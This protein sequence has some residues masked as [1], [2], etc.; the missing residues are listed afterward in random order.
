MSKDKLDILFVN[1]FY[2]EVE[3]FSIGVLS[4]VTILEN[5][6]IS[7]RIVDLNDD[8]H[9]GIVQVGVG[10]C[11]D[12]LL[13]YK[14]PIIG[15]SCM[16]N[17]Y[18][19]YLK[20]AEQIKKVNSDTIILFGGPQ[21]SMTAE[22]T[23]EMFQ[24]IDGVF[25]GE[26]EEVIVDNIRYFLGCGDEKNLKNILDRKNGCVI[27]AKDSP[28]IADLDTLP[29]LNYDLLPNFNR[30][31]TILIESGRGC[32]F[33]CVF[34]STKTFWKRKPRLKSVGRLIREIEEIVQKYDVHRFTM[35]HDLFT[36]NRAY[37]V[38]FCNQIINSSIDIKWSCSARVDTVDA[39]LIK[40]MYDAGC[41]SIF[42]GV[43]VGSE[44]MQRIIHKGLKLNTIEK[45]L[46]ELSKYN[47]D[48]LAFSFM[49]NFPDE[50]EESIHST[51]QLL[52]H[53]LHD[54]EFDVQLGQCCLLPGT[55][56]YEKYCDCLT[57]ESIENSMTLSLPIDMEDSI[58]ADAPDIFTQYYVV[59]SPVF[60]KYL[61]LEP[62]M[63]LYI[64]LFRTF[65]G[66]LEVINHYYKSDFF[67]FYEE[68]TNENRQWLLDVLGSINFVASYYKEGN[69]SQLEAGFI[70]LEHLRAWFNGRFSSEE[71]AAMEELICYLKLL[72]KCN[73]GELSNSVMYKFK[74]DVVGL[75][76]GHT[77]DNCIGR[78]VIVKL[79]RQNDGSVSVLRKFADS[80]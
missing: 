23:M 20:I 1:P 13:S 64:C 44:K 69:Y 5:N 61:L 78:G 53:I 70:M 33:S 66:V 67:K 8:F 6:S 55:E 16:S 39:E 2:Y 37:V 10:Q 22:R 43:E 49:Y 12:Y 71:I 75:N 3:S 60:Q 80:Q 27:K 46:Q 42:F 31:D 56:L 14:S 38:D 29:H 19:F 48:D 58:I 76:K 57:L 41:T 79:I 77:F 68:F 30:F 11:A 74:N 65:R 36:C 7:S 15:F 25:I 32:P 51:V 9:K 73:K 62:F 45:L 34:C 28:F 63:A 50:T 59:D 47:F 35:V 26:S 21:A 52:L 40:L 54:Y 18:Y 72:H 24:F 17:C 4:L